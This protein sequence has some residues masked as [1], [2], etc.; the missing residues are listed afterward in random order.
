MSSNA[1]DTNATARATPRPAESR[2]VGW[3]PPRRRFPSS[4]ARRSYLAPEPVP[5][6]VRRVAPSLRSLALRNVVLAHRLDQRVL[7][8]GGRLVGALAGDDVG[9]GLL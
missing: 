7:V 3:V 1:G 6:P 9:G 4:R 8:G 5:R 2:C